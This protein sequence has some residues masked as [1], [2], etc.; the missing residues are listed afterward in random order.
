LEARS[1]EC[2]GASAREFDRLL[3]KQHAPRRA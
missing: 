1:C 2:Y 3:G